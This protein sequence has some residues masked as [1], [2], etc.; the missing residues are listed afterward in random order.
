MEGK[1]GRARFMMYG[2]ISVGAVAV[3]PWLG[4]WFLLPLLFSLIV[5]AAL[6]RVG[7]N[8]ERR[9]YVVAVAIFV[10][11]IAYGVAVALT[12]GATSPLLPVMLL[13]VA[14]LPTRFTTRGVVA[15][16]VMT[17]AV[18]LAATVGVDHGAFFADPT[19]LLVNVAC[20][21]GIATCSHALM[22]SE[23]LHRKRAVLDPLTGLL[24][25]QALPER[26]AELAELA[27]VTDG[28]VALIECD[29]DRFKAIN[30]L[31]GHA[32]GDVVLREIAAG[33]RKVLRSFELV[34]RLGGEE[35]LIVLPGADVA[36]AHVLAERIRVAIEQGRPGGLPVTASMGIAAARGSAVAFAPL[37]ELAD[38]ALYQAKRAG[39]NRVIAHSDPAAVLA[40]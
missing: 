12:G 16:V 22:R 5:G 3:T 14:L 18:M 38:R 36:E 4:A 15:G 8:V 27:A 9:E 23:V 40:A 37:F 19:Y 26:F 11:Q 1:L 20:M 7:T 31:H 34:Y 13:T 10:V 6:P 33:L 39:R 24:N 25:R 30:D 29:I 17:L 2:S 21:I 28:S 35:F 32:R